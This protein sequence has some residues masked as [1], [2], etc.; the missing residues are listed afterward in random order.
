LVDETECQNLLD[1][2]PDGLFVHLDRTQTRMAG[3]TGFDG[4]VR[5]TLGDSHS[6]RIRLGEM[7]PGTCEIVELPP[8]YRPE[9]LMEASFRHRVPEA[10]A[11]E[12]IWVGPATPGYVSLT[13]LPDYVPAIMYF[14]EQRLFYEEPP[15]SLRLLNRA[16]RINM[17]YGR[18]AYGGSTITQQLVKNVFLDRDKTLARK[19]EEAIIAWAVFNTLSRDKILELYI[20][21]IEFAPNVWGVEAGARYYFGISARQLS[22]IQASFLA[23]LKPSPR[24]GE[25]HRRRGHSP[26]SGRWPRRLH[27]HLQR[28]AD[29]GFI[30][31][32]YVEAHAPYVVEFGTGP[33]IEAFE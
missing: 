17:I 22:P 5:Y 23:G 2:F 24:S 3:L 31:Q 29:H 6:F 18:W 15:V 14:S 10:Y 33:E 20:N 26:T 25:R 30:D 1:I 28:L 9:L 21:C 16:I 27:N 19:F 32:S 4:N 12:E 8:D 11:T 13:E 7:F